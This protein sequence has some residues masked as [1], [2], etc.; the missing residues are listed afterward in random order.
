MAVKRFNPFDWTEVA[1]SG[2][3]L[4]KGTAGRLRLRIPSTQALFISVDGYEALVGVGTDFDVIVGGDYYFRFGGDDSAYLYDPD[5]ECISDCSVIFSSLDRRPELSSA[6]A[7]VSQ[8]VRLFEIRQRRAMAE[9]ADAERRLVALG[10]SYLQ[11]KEPVLN[12]DAP[13]ESGDAGP[14][15]GTAD[16]PATDLSKVSETNGKQ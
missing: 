16:D 9:M 6:M 8:S 2:S 7:E 11:P 14:E 4:I 13:N 10:R 5:K 12:D 15:K 3:K 1:P